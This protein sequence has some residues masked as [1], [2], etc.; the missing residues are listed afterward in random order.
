MATITGRLK[1]TKTCV[2]KFPF[3][4]KK[5]P[6]LY[7]VKVFKG[8]KSTFHSIERLLNKKPAQKDMS[9]PHVY[10]RFYVKEMCRSFS[11]FAPLKSRPL[12]LE[13][14]L[15]STNLT[16]HIPIKLGSKWRV[17]KVHSV[18]NVTWLG[19]AKLKLMNAKFSSPD[20]ARIRPISGCCSVC[21]NPGRFR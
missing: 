11:L 4:L 10:L 18:C 17:P 5:K 14:F 13:F 9:L 19:L 20:Y 2:R 1:N 3:F 21:V 12:I 7:F 8:A 6:L 15:P 16:E